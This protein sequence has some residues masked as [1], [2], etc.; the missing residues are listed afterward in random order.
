MGLYV[1]PYDHEPRGLYYE[2]FAD[3]VRFHATV[4]CQGATLTFDTTVAS[5]THLVDCK[6]K[7]EVHRQQ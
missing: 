7:I 3:Y 1:P 6:Y 4:E 2:L 5:F